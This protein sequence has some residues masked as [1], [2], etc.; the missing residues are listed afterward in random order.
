MKKLIFFILFC[1]FLFAEVI[2]I[3]NISETSDLDKYHL[4]IFDL[5]NTILETAQLLGSDQW[6]YHR[7][8][9]YEND[10]LDS[11]NALDKTLLEWYEIQSIT[12]VKLVEKDIKNL[13]ENLQNRKIKVMGLTTRNVDFAFASIKQLDSLNINLCKTAPYLENLVFENGQ[14]FKKGILFADGKNKGMALKYFFEKIGFFPKSIVF[15]DDKLKHVLEVEDFCKTYKIKFLG[16][17]Y[18]FLDEKIKNFN[19]QISNIQHNN[20]KN[21]LSDEEA[22]KML[23]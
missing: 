22:I 3:K 4:V 17:R 15:I 14:I 21:I 20:L 10:G 12:Q 5:D 23:K 2:E 13:I 16:Y 9:K 19:S 11:K 7:L 8:K 18:G 6:F 1:N